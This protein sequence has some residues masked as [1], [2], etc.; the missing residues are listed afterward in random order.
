MSEAQAQDV[1][2]EDAF[3]ADAQNEVFETDYVVVP[4]GEYSMSVKQGSTKIIAGE[5]DGRA[6]RRYT[7]RVVIDDEKAREATNLQAPGAALRFFLDLND[8]GSALA[9]GTNK[10]IAL[11]RLLKATGNANP[12]WSFKA[13]EGVPF[14]G[15]VKHVADRDDASKVYA[16]VDQFGPL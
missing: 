8:A 1:F 9:S 14:K 4:E 5:K 11:G 16:E 13:I 3:L 12:G 10:N 2:D 15:H 7:A 6:W